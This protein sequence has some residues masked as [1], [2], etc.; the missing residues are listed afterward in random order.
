LARLR[1]FIFPGIGLAAA[2]LKLRQITDDM[3]YAASVAVSESLTQ[4]DRCVPA[5]ALDKGSVSFINS[6]LSQGKHFRSPLSRRNLLLFSLIM[7]ET[8]P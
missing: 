1:R 3:L 8:L 2:V 7:K 5:P 6:S 4:E